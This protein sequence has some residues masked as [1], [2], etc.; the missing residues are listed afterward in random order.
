VI[1]DAAKSHGERSTAALRLAYFRRAD[2]PISLSCLR[3][4]SEA[5]IL[6]LPGEAFVEYQL[7]TA[8][9][10]PF[11]AVAA[12]GDTGTGYIPLARSYAE[13]GYEVR[14]ASVSAGAEPI[15]R[16]AIRRL[17]QP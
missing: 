3:L 11:V 13:G 4:G 10:A 9:Q 17:L 2:K 15:M 7:S 1:A 6:H 12:Y 8:E 14:A 5:S 16:D